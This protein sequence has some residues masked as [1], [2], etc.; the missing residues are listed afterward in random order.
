MREAVPNPGLDH[1]A[2]GVGF[3][4]RLTDAGSR[5]VVELA[6]CALDRLTHRGG[7]DSDGLSGDGAGL[8][9]PIPKE[10]FRDRAERA[11]IRLPED[12]GLGMV[13]LPK[14]RETDARKAVESLAE[15][16]GLR[17]LG[18]R[19]VPL[20]GA[21]LGSRALSTQPAVR[22]CFFRAAQPGGDLERLLFFFRKRVEAEGEPGTYFCSLSS[23]TVVYKGLLT[24]R[25]FRDF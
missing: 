10:F 12:F 7:V 19:V 20:E 15:K 22:Q 14:Q 4:A 18:W 21:T 9:L 5:E 24:P 25:Q 13:F 8:L 2:C 23:R 1:D 16:S 3:V 17:C 11:D 6:L